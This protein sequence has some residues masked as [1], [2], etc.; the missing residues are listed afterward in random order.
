MA[1]PGGPL[2]PVGKYSS[3]E[4]CQGA[5]AQSAMTDAKASKETLT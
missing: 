2:Q 4:A 3:L 5:V 1:L